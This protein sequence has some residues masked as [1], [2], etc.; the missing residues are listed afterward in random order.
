MTILK[1][2]H[3]QSGNRAVTDFFTRLLIDKIRCRIFQ[4]HRLPHRSHITGVPASGGW[5]ILPQQTSGRFADPQQAGQTEHF[6]V[7]A[8]QFCIK[9]SHIFDKPAVDQ[10]LLKR[11]RQE[12][13]VPVVTRFPQLLGIGID[14]DTAILVTGNQFEVLGVSKVLIYE[15]GR[16]YY[17]LKAGDRFAIDRRQ[18]LR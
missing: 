10:H 16:P 18:V 15:H 4:P 12:D 14:E 6:A 2:D 13:L 1:A 3:R 17:S 11:N 8:F 7:T 9:G 5:L